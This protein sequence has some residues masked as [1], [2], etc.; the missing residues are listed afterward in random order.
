[1][2]L[3]QAAAVADKGIT[4]E[5]Y[6]LERLDAIA[7]A[8][9]AGTVAF[10][11]IVA[12]GAT[13]GN[14]GPLGSA[15]G[16]ARALEPVAG[17]HAELLF[18]IGLLGASALAAAV[19]PL[20]TAYALSEAIGVERS[21]SRTFREA[22]LFLGLFTGQIAVG[23][24]MALL[25]GNL[26]SLLIN[27]YVLDHPHVLGFLVV[28]TSRRRLL[29][30]ATNPQPSAPSPPWSSPSSACSPPSCWPRPSSAGSASAN[31]PPLLAG[32]QPR[33]RGHRSKRFHQRHARCQRIGEPLRQP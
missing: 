13:I 14:T 17:H 4:P 16:A 10:F 21:V 15:A 20:S 25:P 9:F 31:D 27:A 7:G 23:A 28:L 5:Q 8:V 32:A 2:Q 24:A 22:P 1:M 30:P 19:V 26:I 29:S 33:C 6:P 11:I 3:Y 18:G 12:T